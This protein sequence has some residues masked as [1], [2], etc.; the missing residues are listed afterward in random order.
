MADPQGESPEDISLESMLPVVTDELAVDPLLLALL[1]CAAFLDFADD[2]T[3]EPN[4]ATEVLDHVAYYVRRI[5]AERL[6]QLQSQLRR[7]EEHG[8]AEGWPPELVEFVGDFLDN[9]T[10]DDDDEA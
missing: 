1:Q 4:S 7:V 10:A 5:P 3:V 6:G 9:C 2:E 8:A